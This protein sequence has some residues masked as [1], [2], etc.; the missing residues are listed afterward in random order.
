M[1]E[2][3]NT[4]SPIT[5]QYNQYKEEKAKLLPGSTCFCLPLRSGVLAIGLIGSTLAISGLAAY[6]IVQVPTLRVHVGHYFTNNTERQDMRVDEDFSLQNIAYTSE[7]VGAIVGAS[8]GLLVNILLVFGVLWSRRWF[9]MHWLVFHVVALVLLFITSILVFV[10]QV[11]LW[12]LMGIVP[13]LLAL[14]TMYCWAKVYELFGSM[15]PLPGQDH[16]PPCKLHPLA[17]SLTPPFMLPPPPWMEEPDRNGRAISMDQVEE[18]G[19]GVEFYPVDSLSRGMVDR[20]S[21]FNRSM[22]NMVYLPYENMDDT[23]SSWTKRS[24][25]EHH[26]AKHEYQPSNGSTGSSIIQYQKES[27]GDEAII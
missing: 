26:Q 3:V 23:R 1:W 16:Q 5:M 17:N 21:L 25:M 24:S 15:H 10:V 8:T 9:L 6:A 12:K 19:P 4:I 7:I 22:N 13:V 18:L 2:K 11:A 20:M 27:T 14:F